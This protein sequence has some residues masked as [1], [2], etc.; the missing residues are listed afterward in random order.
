MGTLFAL[1]LALVQTFLPEYSR[2]ALIVLGALEILLWTRYEEQPEVGG[3]ASMH[4]TVTA[5]FSQQEGMPDIV[6]VI[7][8]AW[9]LSKSI[10]NAAEDY[11]LAQFIAVLLICFTNTG[12][13][14]TPIV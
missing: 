11:L 6:T 9:R 8:K 14:I 7:Q 10:M 13:V 4:R 1:L 12:P 3:I 2:R 5:V